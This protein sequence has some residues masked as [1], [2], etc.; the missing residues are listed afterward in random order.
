MRIYVLV[1]GVDPLRLFVF[2]EGLARFA[3]QEYTGAI[4]N[5]MD[6][7]YIHL[8]NYSINMH[9]QNFIANKNENEDYLGHKRSLTSVLTHI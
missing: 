9:A 2:Q 5:N 6:N 8:T 4:E 7:L 1:Y 3:T